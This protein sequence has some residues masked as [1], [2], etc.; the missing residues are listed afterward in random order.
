[1]SRKLPSRAGRLLVVLRELQVARGR[2]VTLREL[3][4][5]TGIAPGGVWRSEVDRARLYRAMM[6]L[7]NGRVA[8]MVAAGDTMHDLVHARYRTVGWVPTAAPIIK[9]TG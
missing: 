9:G 8:E 7:R 6:Q 1:M 5:A 3:G 2:P 4:E